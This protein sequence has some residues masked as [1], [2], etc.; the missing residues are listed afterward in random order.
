MATM[1]LILRGQPTAIDLCLG[2]VSTSRNCNMAMAPSSS[3]LNTQQVIPIHPIQQA[4]NLCIFVRTSPSSATLRSSFNLCV[5]S[6]RSSSK[7]ARRQRIE[8]GLTAQGLS[9]QI[10]E[11]AHVPFEKNRRSLEVSYFTESSPSSSPSLSENKADDASLHNPLLRLHRMGCGWLGVLLEWEGV[12]V[13]DDSDVERKAW[14]A[15]AEE[16]GKRPPPTFVLNRVEGMKNEQA[17]AEVLCWTRDNRQMKRLA[18]RKEELY[19]EMQ[20]GMYRLRPG[21]R[22]FVETL[23]KYSIPVAMASTRP[24]KYLERAIEAIGMEGFFN[25]VIAAEDVYRGKPDP[26]MFLYAAEQLGFISERCIVFGNSNSSVEAAHD[27]CMKCVAVSGKHP[28]YELGAADLVVRQ[29][30]DLSMVDL[31]NLADL[32]SPEFQTPEPEPEME[33]EEEMPLP[34][35]ATMDW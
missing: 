15:L 18:L 12:I 26:E 3:F 31:K 22:E 10:T 20:G 32:D 8:H 16:E 9:M 4:T 19:E 14:A 2:A 7:S 21:S 27:C 1:G 5:D 29:L 11:E 6:L 24:R 35:V 30:D 23:K 28:V 34:R 33:V 25:V 13:E 17:I